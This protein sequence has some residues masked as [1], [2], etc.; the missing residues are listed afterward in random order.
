M[1]KRVH[2]TIMAIAILP[3]TSVAQGVRDKHVHGHGQLLVAQDDS[4]WQLQFSIPAANLLGFEHEPED[5]KQRDKVHAMETALSEFR[6]V[7]SISGSCK[8]AQQDIHIPHAEHHEDHESHA[9]HAGDDAHEAHRQHQHED[10]SLTY[11]LSCNDDI[12]A[13]TINMFGLAPSLSSLEVQWV[14]DKGQ[15]MTDVTPQAAT[16]NW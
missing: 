15:G 11:Q 9:G 16:I 7:A 10:V 1:F 4:Q 14:T 12:S 13:L 5:Q 2:L 8:V 3:I 6:N